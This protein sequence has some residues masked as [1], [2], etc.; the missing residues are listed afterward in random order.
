MSDADSLEFRLFVSLKRLAAC[1]RP[2][3]EVPPFAKRK[4]AHAV[5]M[6][7]FGSYP[8]LG[9]RGWNQAKTE[10]AL[11]LGQTSKLGLWG[12]GPDGGVLDLKVSD[13]TVCTVHELPLAPLP[14]WRTLV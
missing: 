13:A 9:A 14:G 7:N 1:E 2:A 8:G 5:T 4:R 12:G 6:A 11:G 3:L 10:L